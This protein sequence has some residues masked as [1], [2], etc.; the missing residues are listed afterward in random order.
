MKKIIVA[1]L[2]FCILLSVSGCSSHKGCDCT[3]ENI[4]RQ[5]IS[6]KFEWKE[7]KNIYELLPE[8]AEVIE[9][10]DMTTD[11]NYPKYD[12]IYTIHNCGK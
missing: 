8:N 2:T 9:I 7:E 1:I 3:K 4:Y 5:S 12:I 11:S 6:S 10:I